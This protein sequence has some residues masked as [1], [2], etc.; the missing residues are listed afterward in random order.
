[1][2]HPRK[3]SRLPSNTRSI[4][5]LG[6]WNASLQSANASAPR[7]ADDQSADGHGRDTPVPTLR[8]ISNFG[9]LLAPSVVLADEVIPDKTITQT[10]DKPFGDYVSFQ[11]PVFSAAATLPP[12]EAEPVSPTTTST[13]SEST[14]DAA[15]HTL[16]PRSVSILSSPI[17]P[18]LRGAQSFESTLTARAPKASSFLGDLAMS[19]ASVLSEDLAPSSS[20]DEREWEP[21]YY[22]STQIFDVLQNSKGLP[23]ITTVPEW[24]ADATFKLQPSSSVAPKDDP[25][26]VLWGTRHEEEKSHSDYRQSASSAGRHPSPS[27][28]KPTMQKKSSIFGTMGKSSSA[29]GHKSKSSTTTNSTASSSRSSS[30]AP[31]LSPSFDNSQGPG[32][33][34][35]A[36][37]DEPEGR[38][39][40]LAATIER[41]VAQLTSEFNY[42][43]LLD[44]FLT[45]RTYI[46]PVDLAHLFICRFQWALNGTEGVD[47]KDAEDPEDVTVRR[48]V[49]VRTFIAVRYW[50]LTFFK[51]DFIANKQLCVV[52]TTWLNALGRSPVLQ[53]HADALVSLYLGHLGCVD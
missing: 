40:M 48:I 39:V 26:F 53:S 12:P 22:S 52:L 50:L 46:T 24:P 30:V 47:D 31:S 34:T 4:P 6:R 38:R 14:D 25:R 23:L 18:I 13:S 9:S 16:P 29:G 42:D 10:V 33:V 37:S 49:R 11:T 43:E 8:P 28:N 3:S 27:S 45:Y 17:S 35:T 51:V 5:D 21:T 1:M 2:S 19:P 36:P 7:G 32:S 20:E 15:T 44:F 41:W